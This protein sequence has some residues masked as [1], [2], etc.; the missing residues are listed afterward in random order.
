[1][2][3]R[4]FVAAVGRVRCV[5]DHRRRAEARHEDLSLSVHSGLRPDR[6]DGR[7]HELGSADHDPEG[8]RARLLRSAG[9]PYPWVELRV[10]D[11]DTGRDRATGLVG[12]VWTRS[13]QNMKG[14]WN[15]PDD[16]A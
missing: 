5:A 8:P 2:R 10:V 9:K 3:P 1:H 11:P 12:E 16:T 14:Y 13:I 4:L 6:D 7:D 15:K